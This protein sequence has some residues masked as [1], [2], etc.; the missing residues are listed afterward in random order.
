MAT[1]AKPLGELKRLSLADVFKRQA[2][3][4]QAARDAAKRLYGTGSAAEAPA[5]PAKP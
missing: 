3:S 4:Q 2:D 1:T 5:P